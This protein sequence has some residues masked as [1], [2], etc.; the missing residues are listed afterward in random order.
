V[1]LLDANITSALMQREPEP[2]VVFEERV[3][4]LVASPEL[5]LRFGTVHF[6]A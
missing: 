2:A 4:S 1:I 3:V 6:R 5:H